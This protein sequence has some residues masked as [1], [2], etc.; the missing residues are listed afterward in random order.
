MPE[1]LATF[2]LPRTLSRREILRASLLTAGF[3]ALGPLGRR[4]SVALG[5]PLTNHKRLVVVNMSGGCDTLSMVVPTTL[6]P[7]YDQRA[8]IAVP[9]DQALPVAGTSLYGLHPAMPRLQGLWN[10]GHA[11]AVQRVGYPRANQSHFES[12]DIFSYGV[13]NGFGP[14]GLQPSGWI[15]RY[16]DVHAPT[17]LGAVSVGMGR[18]LDFVGG[19]SNPLL[20]STLSGFRLSGTGSSNARV[21]RL[22]KARALLETASTQGLSGEARSA[23]RAAH[24]LTGDV[25]TALTNHNA[26]LTTSGVTWPGTTPRNTIAD[27]LKDVAALIHGGFETRVFYT[28]WGGFDTHGGQG[29]V[30]GALPTLLGE[31]DAALGSF[32][33]EMKALGIWQDVVVVVITEF[34]RRNYENGSSGSDHGHSYAGLVLGGSVAGA[35]SLGPD[36]TEADLTHPDGFPQYAVDFRSIYKEVLAEHLGADLAPVFPEA[37]EIEQT[38]GLI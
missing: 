11:L 14:L 16:A 3:L 34:G 10:D 30:T 28:G 15:A 19:T 35:R 31:L 27:R 1:S 12:Q 20:V 25:Q 21:Y 24:D 36:L 9:A 7:Y 17:P 8:T 32:S 6:Q 4:A 18:P 29:S 5:A 2:H 38:L 37:L 33:D 13:R 22:E 26:Y 23:L